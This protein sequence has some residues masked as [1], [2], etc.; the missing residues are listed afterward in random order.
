MQFRAYPELQQLKL[1]QLNN[2]SNKMI[3]HFNGVHRYLSNFWMSPVEFEGILYPSS[4]H[5]YQAAKTLDLE[6]R[7]K[8][9]DMKTAGEAKKAGQKVDKQPG[10]EE[11]K[12]EVMES[13]VL[14]KFT[15]NTDLRAQLLATGDQ[16]L[17]EANGWHDIFWGV[18]H[19]SRKC[20]CTGQGENYLGQ[21]L[22]RVRSHLCA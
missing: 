21:V 9:A 15:Q 6:V 19:G 3:A 20:N 11:K 10:W 18:C 22:M 2:N 1:T 5:A 4:E 17:V 12:V 7:Q 16:E 14:A 8:I 13:I